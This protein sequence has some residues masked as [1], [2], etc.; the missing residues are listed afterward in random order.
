MHVDLNPTKNVVKKK[1]PQ[2]PKKKNVAIKIQIL[3]TAQAVLEIVAILHV[4]VQ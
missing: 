2:N 3:A 4:T 1:L